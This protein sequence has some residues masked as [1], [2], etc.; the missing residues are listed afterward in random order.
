[1][2]LQRWVVHL[3]RVSCMLYQSL[4]MLPSPEVALQDRLIRCSFLWIFLEANL[5][6]FIRRLTLKSFML[7]DLTEHTWHLYCLFWWPSGSVTISI[8]V[9]LL[10]FFT[11]GFLMETSCHSIALAEAKNLLYMS[12]VSAKTSAWTS[13]AQRRHQVCKGVYA[14]LLYAYCMAQYVTR[15]KSLS[16]T[17][18]ANVALSQAWLS[19]LKTYNQ[20]CLSDLRRYARTTC[21]AARASSLL[22]RKTWSNT[23]P[24]ARPRAW[25]PNH[26]Y[27]DAWE[28][29]YVKDVALRRRENWG[30]TCSSQNMVYLEIMHSQ[31]T[32]SCLHRCTDSKACC[33]A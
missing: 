15:S 13:Q 2:W 24:V 16:T 9:T 19:R 8:D 25:M 27:H 4:C 14:C 17:N 7:P 22:C 28:P 18:A 21:S 23:T 32:A 26:P 11:L 30:T 12:R 5:P 3:L 33:C 31:D 29:T 10:P 6:W 20:R 1:M